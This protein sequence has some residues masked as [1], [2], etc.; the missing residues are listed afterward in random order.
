[1]I[2]ETHGVQIDLDPR[3][4]TPSTLAEDVERAASIVD[5]LEADEAHSQF[6]PR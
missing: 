4:A 6:R 3:Q 5:S 2:Y 1:M